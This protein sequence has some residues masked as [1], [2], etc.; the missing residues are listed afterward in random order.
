MHKGLVK[1]LR[2]CSTPFDGSCMYCPYYKGAFCKMQMM[3]DAASL[4]E[5]LMCEIEDLRAE[6]KDLRW[7]L[8]EAYNH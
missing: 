1:A 8:N 3:E 6:N 4:I 5:N 2:N 7:E